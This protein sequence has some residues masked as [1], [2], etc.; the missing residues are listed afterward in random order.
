MKRP[1]FRNKLGVLRDLVSEMARYFL[2]AA[3]AVVGQATIIANPDILSGTGT[4]AI[5]GSA[6][7]IAA[8][9]TVSGTG[10]VTSAPSARTA[11]N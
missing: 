1:T 7:I 8:P 6:A 9:D 4:V 5:Q 3:T 11:S 2:V 10:T